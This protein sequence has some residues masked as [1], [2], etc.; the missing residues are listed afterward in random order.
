MKRH[1]SPPKSPVQGSKE[2]PTQCNTGLAS[3]WATNSMRKWTVLL[4][5]HPQDM[6]LKHSSCTINVYLLRNQF[7]I[8]AWKLLGRTVRSQPGPFEKKVALN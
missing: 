2:L 6:E 1:L 8:V 4:C 3:E 7:I 5:S